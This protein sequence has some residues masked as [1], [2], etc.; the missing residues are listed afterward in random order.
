MTYQNEKCNW[1]QRDEQNRNKSTNKI[2][3][4]SLFEYIFHN[5]C[6]DIY[7]LSIL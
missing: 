5:I 4:G 2:I 6:S 1:I 7:F 3:K